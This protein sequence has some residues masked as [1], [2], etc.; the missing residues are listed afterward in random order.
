VL[1]EH[2]AVPKSALESAVFPDSTAAAAMNG[3]IRA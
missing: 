1:A 3:L 2:M